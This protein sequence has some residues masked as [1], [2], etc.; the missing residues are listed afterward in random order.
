MVI[1]S[2][3]TTRWMSA[4]DMMK[5]PVHGGVFRCVKT[6]VTHAAP[7]LGLQLYFHPMNIWISGCVCSARE[8]M[9]KASAKPVP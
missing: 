7:S 2:Y 5:R 9:T 6:Q 8:A 3:W 4:S 1:I